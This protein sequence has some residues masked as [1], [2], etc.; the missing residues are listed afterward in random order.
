MRDPYLVL[1]VGRTATADDIKAA[2]RRLAKQYHPDLN[3]GRADIELKFKE[4]NAAYSLLSDPEKRARFD[5]GEID[6]S[7]AERPDRSFRRAY[8]GAGA[9]RAGGADDPFNFGD[10]P[11]SDIFGAGRRRYGAH[12][13]GVKAKGAD[14]AYSVTVPFADACLGTK[15]RLSLSTGKSIDVVIPPGTRDQSKLRLKGQGLAGLGGAGAGDAIVEVH[16]DP[17]PHFTRRDDDIHLDVPVTLAEAV[18]GA[19]IKVPT[20]DGQVAVK[21]PKGANTG[22]VLRLKGKGVPNPERKVNGDQYVKLVVVLPDRPD[23]E[24]T[25]FIEKWAKTHEYDVRRKAG[26]G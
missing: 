16:V 9:G 22:T 13:A 5:K 21:V 3:P 10:D 24:L 11:F 12:S 1:G 18:L 2:Y 6:A 7:G 8:A 4:V 26:L 14:V 17:H 15:R 25:G 23:A 20:L 19:T